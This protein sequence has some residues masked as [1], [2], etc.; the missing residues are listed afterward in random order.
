MGCKD[1]LHSWYDTS[2]NCTQYLSWYKNIQYPCFLLKDSIFVSI[3]YTILFMVTKM[4]G[5]N[6][7]DY[8]H[9][10]QSSES[11]TCLQIMTWLPQCRYNVFELARQVMLIHVLPK[12][13]HI[14]KWH[15]KWICIN[16]CVL[17]HR[18]AQIMYRDSSMKHQCIVAALVYWLFQSSR[19]HKLRLVRGEDHAVT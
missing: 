3:S 9:F 8:C 10:L 16:G 6:R 5:S 1:T 2:I 19:Y 13:N 12:I 4:L 14:I 7:A 17:R 15:K 11:S 18:L